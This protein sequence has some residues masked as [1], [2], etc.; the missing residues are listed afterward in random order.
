MIKAILFD[1]DGV[2]TIDKTG[3]ESIIRFISDKSRIPLE[4]VKTNYYKYNRELLSG[5][6]THKDMWNSFC[7]DIGQKLDYSILIEAFK[8]TL[9]D[10]EMIEFLK[11]LKLNYLIALVTDNKVDRINTILEYSDLKKY[12]DVV[13]IS[14]KLKSRKDKRYIFE[15]TILNLKI[16][17]EECVFIDNTDRNL[18][19]PKSMGICTILFDDERRCIHK[20]K[21]DLMSLI[22]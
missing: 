12:F 5:E 14:A 8:N 21:Q 11:E 19:I 18:I 2:L 13:S 7:N 1:F 6:I 4:V 15:D 16:Q 3:S 22:R 10:K 17:P 20:F 9:L